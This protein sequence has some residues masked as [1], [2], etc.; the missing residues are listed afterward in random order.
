MRTLRILLAAA[1]VLLGAS[2]NA[3]AA[4]VARGSAESDHHG[5]TVELSLDA[6]TWSEQSPA[7]FSHARLLPG[8]SVSTQ[9]WIRHGGPSPATLSITA[10]SPAATGEELA[11][12]L[13]LQ[14]AGTPLVPGQTW[15]GPT[16][17]PGEAVAIPIEVVLAA[18]APEDVRGRSADVLS[19]LTVRA[20][21]RH[22]GPPPDNPGRLPDT[23]GVV[24]PLVVV[25]AVLLTLGAA[26][27]HSAPRVA[28]Q[29]R[30]SAGRSD[31][32]SPN[33]RG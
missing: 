24:V 19:H 11:E 8:R 12:W 28:R 16:A 6:V 14:V 21:P 5:T 1:L 9:L 7:L 30:H 18:D 26:A 32:G 31:Q 23:G 27:R 2:L 4:D 13:T 3:S 20:T 33:I 15:Q 22:D 10:A 17:A 25:A 29:P